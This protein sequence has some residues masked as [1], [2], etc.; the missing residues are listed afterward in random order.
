MNSIAG[1]SNCTQIDLRDP[2]TLIDVCNIRYVTSEKFDEKGLMRDLSRVAVIIHTAQD[3][4][5]IY[6]EKGFRK[7]FNVL[8]FMSLNK[9]K[10]FLKS[11]TFCKGLSAFVIYNN[12]SDVLV[13]RRV[14]FNGSIPYSFQFFQGY[15]TRNILEEVNLDLITE[16]LEFIKE[17]IANNNIEVY[18][19]LL[20]WF[21]FIIQRVGERTGKTIVLQ[22]ENK[23]GIV[24]FTEILCKLIEPYSN[25]Y[26]W[27]NW[28]SND[29]K[30]LLVFN[31]ITL[32]KAREYLFNDTLMINRKDGA[33]RTIEN[34]SNLIIVNDK[35]GKKVADDSKFIKLNVSS[36]YSDNQNY[37]EDLIE[38]C[39]ENEFLDNLLT[40]FMQRNLSGFSIKESPVNKSS[41]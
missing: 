26:L 22:G 37:F 4:Y 41:A 27:P 28:L 30:M 17:V 31:E 32:P 18:E 15:Y 14:S 3:N 24:V 36:K 34:V 39:T 7:D 10:N 11:I 25:H 33:K 6:K 20:N 2:F 21:A 13:K 19:Y 29:F 9:F 8:K 5:V 40:F 35:F 1:N 16:F 23:E 12:Y 38:S